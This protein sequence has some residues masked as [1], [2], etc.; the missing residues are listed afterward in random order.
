MKTYEFRF[1]AQ[2]TEFSAH[3]ASVA[4]GLNATIAEE[5]KVCTFAEAMA[6]LP[7]FSQ[8]AP[9]PHRAFL[10]MRYRSDRVPPGF[11]KAC[12]HTDKLN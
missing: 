6:Y 3:F 9:G 1:N 4:Y 12:R 10:G 5:I 11:L 8:A 2:R 7:T